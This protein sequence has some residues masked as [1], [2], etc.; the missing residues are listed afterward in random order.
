MDQRPLPPV[1]RRAGA[2]PVRLEHDR[3]DLPGLRPARHDGGHLPDGA[4]PP[5]RDRPGSRHLRRC[6]SRAGS[7]SA[8]APARRSTSPCSARRW[9]EFE[10]RMEMLEESVELIREL[11][12]GDVVSRRGRHYQREQ[13]PDLHAA[14]PAAADLRQ[15]L[16][17][18]GGQTP[19]PAS[20]T[21]TSAPHPTR[22]SWARS[23]TSRAA[24]RPRPGARWPGRTPATRASTRPIGCG[25]TPGCPGSW[26]RSC[27]PRAL[28]AG[29]GAGHPRVDVRERRGRPDVEEHLDQLRK[30]ADAGYDE[31]YVANMG[32]QLPGDDRGL[33]LRGP[34]RRST[35]PGEGERHATS[36]RTAGG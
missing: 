3:R 21:A 36:R 8:S 15:R 4:H 10:V 16:R 17:P 11:W 25:R 23:R 20:P 24:S 27:P 30:Y 1:E 18:E 26:R 2:E 9:P 13:R 5:G 29:L 19:S 34:A 12:K 32:A 6:C 33:R 28:R 22:S 14:R 31:I 35:R 7:S